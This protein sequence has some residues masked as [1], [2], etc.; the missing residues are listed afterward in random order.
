MP[1][2][3]QLDE[4]D[5]HIL[6]ILQE[7]GRRRNTDL[8]DAIGMTP[9]PCLRRVKALEESGLIRK[10]VALLDPPLAGQTLTVIVEVK[11]ASQTIERIKAFEKAVLT[12]PNVLE[13][14]LVTG[15]WDYVLKICVRDL[16]EFQNFLV[17]RLTSLREVQSLKSTIAM[18]C[19]KQTTALHIV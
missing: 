12:L 3:I 8:A 2:A 4:T 18:K 13:C 17:Q 6:R 15:D 5:K 19:V 14:Y 10:Y 16:D 7:D 11:L 1:A 9:A